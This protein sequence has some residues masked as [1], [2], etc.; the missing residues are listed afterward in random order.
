MLLRML[1]IKMLLINQ[2]LR[3]AVDYGTWRDFMEGE[4]GF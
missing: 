2:G 3:G 1:S 4:K